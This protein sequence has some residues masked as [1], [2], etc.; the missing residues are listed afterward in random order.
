MTLI[1]DLRSKNMVYDDR[2]R[3]NW[4]QV[5]AMETNLKWSTVGEGVELW[6]RLTAHTVIPMA[7]QAAATEQS[8]AY[9]TDHTHTP[10]TH[11]PHTPT[12]HT[13]HTQTNHTHTN[14]HTHA[15]KHPCTRSI[16]T[17][18]NF[19]I[20]AQLERGSKHRFETDEDSN[21]G[22]KMWRSIVL[23]NNYMGLTPCRVSLILLQVLPSVLSK[24]QVTWPVEVLEHSSCTVSVRH[25]VW[26]CWGHYNYIWYIIIM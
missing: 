20:Y 24:F 23:G 7:L 6:E 11:T 14:T 4:I 16:L 12:T 8:Q 25:S 22:Q 13:P 18:Q 21:T 1:H 19:L 10:H 26:N 17:I 2:E 3:W 9:F 15:Q 5:P